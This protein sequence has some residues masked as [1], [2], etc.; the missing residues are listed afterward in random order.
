[1]KTGAVLIFQRIKL[2]CASG[3]FCS[4]C[5]SLNIIQTLGETWQLGV[6]FFLSISQQCKISTDHIGVTWTCVEDV[7][8][9]FP[10]IA[11]RM[12]GSVLSFELVIFLT[13]RSIEIHSS[14]L[15]LQLF[16]STRIGQP[17]YQPDFVKHSLLI[18][19]RF[20]PGH[21]QKKTYILFHQPIDF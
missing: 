12:R 19:T 8:L 15:R 1:M 11:N 9:L 18:R 16:F 2:W 10:L 5:W 14:P 7:F 6:F 20:I 17:Q 13:F 21:L 3:I 4:S